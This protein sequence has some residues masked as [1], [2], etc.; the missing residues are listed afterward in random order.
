MA[1]GATTGSQERDSRIESG[2]R[3]DGEIMENIIYFIR[4]NSAEVSVLC[5]M[6]IG[7]LCFHM[8]RALGRQEGGN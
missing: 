8:G 1:V 3:R 2:T 4:D 6:A 5:A 7:F